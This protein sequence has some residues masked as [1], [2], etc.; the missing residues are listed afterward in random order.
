MKRHIR[1]LGANKDPRDPNLPDEQ[2]LE[3][4]TKIIPKPN[5]HLLIP[6]SVGG[7]ILL[8]GAAF[9][10]V[11]SSTID[12]ICRQAGNCQTFKDASGKAQDS[13]KKAEDG[14]KSA[15]SL[16]ELLTIS[17]SIDEAKSSLA[18]VSDN[19]TDLVPS[20]GEQ[21]T[22]V[23]ELDKKIGVLLVVEQNADK[24]LKEAIAKIVSA[25]QLNRDR[26]GATETPDNAKNRLNKPKAI[27]VEAQ[28]LLQSIPDNSFAVTSKKEKLKQ[29]T[30]KI[31]DLDGK[32]GAIAA[33]D[34]CVINPDS[35]KP[36]DPCVANPAACAAP[37]VSPP[38]APVESGYDNPPPPPQ[39]SGKRPLFGPGSSGY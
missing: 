21:R 19:A 10:F 32:I 24:S 14:L 15:K 25:D 34:P 16:P 3:L 7:A 2:N 22:K 33:L 29:V 37:P 38:D 18:N 30:D 4:E 35:C 5:S 20:I 11:N 23:A 26:Q 17:K 31:K 27:Y 8:G 1:G 36:V 12:L 39:S 9:L 28:V 13:M 6:L